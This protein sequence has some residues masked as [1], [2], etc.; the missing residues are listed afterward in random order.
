MILLWSSDPLHTLE[1]GETLA[2]GIP[3][4]TDSKGAA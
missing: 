2:N 3:T 1:P 4:C